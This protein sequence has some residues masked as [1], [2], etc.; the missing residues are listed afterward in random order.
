MLLI[1]KAQQCYVQYEMHEKLKNSN[2]PFELLTLTFAEYQ[3][4]K[5]NSNEISLNRKMYDIK[6]VDISGDSVRLLAIND[7]E[8]ENILEKIKNFIE[9]SDPSNSALPNHLY[10]LITL[11]YLQV[12]AENVFYLPMQS[13]N[14]FHSLSANISTSDSDIPSPPPRF[15]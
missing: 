2:T 1:F 15:Y 3:K 9:K 4:S 12:T 5:I 7:Y 11:V 6:S 13:I 10:K 8:E 14:V